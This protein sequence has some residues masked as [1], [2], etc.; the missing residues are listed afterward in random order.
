MGILGILPYSGGQDDGIVV[1]E[2]R[3]DG[4]SHERV[5]D[6]A[7]REDDEH[8][9]EPQRQGVLPREGQS[10]CKTYSYHYI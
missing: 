1:L 3:E 4:L 2:G 7:A 9:R 8:G 10:G 5:G 6:H